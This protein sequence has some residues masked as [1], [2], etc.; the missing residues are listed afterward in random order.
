MEHSSGHDSKDLIGGAIMTGFILNTGF[1]ALVIV[2]IVYMGS[3]AIR[4]ILL[5]V[6][7]ED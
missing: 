7:D 5:T 6:F 3:K 1:F 2:A 4:E